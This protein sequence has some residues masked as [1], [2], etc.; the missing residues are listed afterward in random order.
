MLRSYLTTGWRSTR[1]NAG[2]AAI[3]VA[4]LSIGMA[5]TIMIFLWLNGEL[6]VNT[7]FEN[8]D[9]LGKVYHHLRF[10]G[11]IVTHDGISYPYGSA[12]KSQFADFEEVAMTTNINDHLVEAGDVKFV[13][14]GF[15]LTSLF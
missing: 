11:D 5:A 2:I 14:K 6:H 9:R 10:G 4:G 7:T 1:R 3:N 13:R 8:Y 15:L 12:I